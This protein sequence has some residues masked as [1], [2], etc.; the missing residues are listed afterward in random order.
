MS[1]PHWRDA[2]ISPS[3]TLQKAIHTI[4]KGRAQIALV[5]D[6]NYQLLGTVTD[7]DIR[8]ALLKEASMEILV[9]TVMT[10]NPVSVRPSTH[11]NAV[12]GLMKRKSLHQ[13]P[14]VDSNN[15]VIGMH[16]WTDMPVVSHDNTVVIMAGGFGARMGKHTKNCPKPMLKVRGKPLLQHII[17][18]AITNGFT[19]FLISLHYLPDIIENYFGDG[20]KWGVD[21]EYVCE[22]SPLGTVGS[23]SLWA[24]KPNLPFIVTNG[25][26]MSDVRFGEMLDFHIAQSATATM[27]VREHQIQNPYGVVNLSEFEI[28]SFE[29]KPI[30]RSYI[31]AGV[32]ILDPIALDFLNYNE[33]C[34]MPTLF[35]CLKNAGQNTL[36]YPL[37]ESWMDVGR[38]E[39]LARA[40]TL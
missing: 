13:L 12:L 26:V 17:E 14:I 20:S 27:A 40:H 18:K 1:Y 25:D 6:Q 37:Y 33:R 2:L 31:N 36:A 29:E 22:D 23:L 35:E 3:N 21:I 32:Y 34:D 15:Q 16:I 24:R 9:E 39:D 4:D 8:R 10:T 28:T 11:P 5:V 30:Y 19:S 7:G 38:P